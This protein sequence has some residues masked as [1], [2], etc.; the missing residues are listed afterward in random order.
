M[1]TSTAS[2]RPVSRCAHS[3]TRCSGVRP[4]APAATGGRAAACEARLAAARAAA[5]RASAAAAAGG[6]GAARGAAAV[7]ML[8]NAARAAAAAGWRGGAP[9]GRAAGCRGVP[10]WSCC[11]SSI[12]AAR[13]RLPALTSRATLLASS[14]K[15][16]EVSCLS[17]PACAWRSAD[18]A[19]PMLPRRATAGGALQKASDS[20]RELQ[21]TTG[22]VGVRK[23]PHGCTPGKHWRCVGTGLGTWTAATWST[24]TR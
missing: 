19:E 2:A 4:L 3:C 10:N 9:P 21:R 5:A 1:S 22:R 15:P 6:T 13:C 11:S 20:G 7:G 23:R 16:I 17:E 8:A 18:S 12:C 24:R 14:L